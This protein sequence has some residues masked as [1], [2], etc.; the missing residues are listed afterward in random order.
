M[1][2]YVN[3][4]LFIYRTIHERIVS[5][6]KLLKKKVVNKGKVPNKPNMLPLHTIEEF[7]RFEELSREELD[8]IVI[9]YIIF[10]YYI[11]TIIN[12]LTLHYQVTVFVY[13]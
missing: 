8:D 10:H 3:F 9:I 1:L 12:V 6:E 2:R 11:F 7:E 5:I 4:I 13:I